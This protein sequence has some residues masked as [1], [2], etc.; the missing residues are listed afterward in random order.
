[1]YCIAVSHLRYVVK[2]RDGPMRVGYACSCNK[3]FSPSS[4][5][6]C[7]KVK[8]NFA[9]HFHLAGQFF[10]VILSSKV[11]PTLILIEKMKI[12]ICMVSQFSYF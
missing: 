5:G 11:F 1:M 6:G 4:K 3:L 12:A 7:K 9:L 8:I 2:K 10:F